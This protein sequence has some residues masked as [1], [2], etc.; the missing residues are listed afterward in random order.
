[1]LS[2][3]PFPLSLFLVCLALLASPAHAQPPGPGRG[4]PATCPWVSFYGNARQM[5]NL[6]R[7]A[8][9][10][11]V[12]NLDAD[13]HMQNFQK[14]QIATLK[15]KG[16]N[17]VLSYLNVGACERYRDYYTKAPKGYLSCQDNRRAHKGIYQDYP[18]EM[19]MDPANPDYQRLLIEV[20]AP[21]LVA[22]GVDGFYLDN[23]EILE[24]GPSNREAPCDKAC[25]QGGL[26]LIAKLR[27]AFPQHLLV[28][29]N[30][31]SD[32]IR[33][34]RLEDGAALAELLDGIAR[35][36]TYTPT[37][38]AGVETDLLAW[39]AMKLTPGGRPF[40]I[41]T[42]DFVGNCRARK[43]AKAI[44]KLARAKGF[45]PFVT[46]QSAGQKVICKF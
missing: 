14:D 39:Q 43:K 4:F 42:L 6:P 33:Q 30:A 36:E 16:K 15:A 24:H 31:T 10:F 21:R 38:D 20:V 44:A 8:K 46:D 25:R 17:R 26:A 1:M 13:P 18:D 27:R 12:I 28:M 32:L 9:R 11:R 7:V 35:E 3:R 29:Q 37:K 23:L 40:F 45:C 22:M 5:G 34:G 41:G 19:W 2:P